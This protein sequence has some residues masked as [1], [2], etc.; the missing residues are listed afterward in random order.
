MKNIFY[1]ISGLLYVSAS[2]G[3]AWFGQT[4]VIAFTKLSQLD[5]FVKNAVFYAWHIPTAE[6]L[7]FGVSFLLA[8]FSKEFV[9]FRY[10]AWVIAVITGARYFVFLGST[11]FHN[12][13]EA[14]STLPQLGSV[15]VFI[16]VIMLGARK[17]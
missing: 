13:S 16:V 1:F 10:A 2:F 17:K 15:I 8:S 4:K 5:L 11:L 3:H 7:I 6:N 12:K 9:K 14:V